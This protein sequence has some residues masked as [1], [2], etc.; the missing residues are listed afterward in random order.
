M[1]KRKKRSRGRKLKGSNKEPRKPKKT[2][3]KKIETIQKLAAKTFDG[4]LPE[5][6]EFVKYSSFDEF[7]DVPLLRGP[8][9][10]N[11]KI[12]DCIYLDPSYPEVLPKGTI[13]G[14]I[15]K[16]NYCCSGPYFYYRDKSLDCIQC[17]ENFTFSA[18]EQKYWYESLQFNLGS[19]AIRCKDCRKQRR[20]VNSLFQQISVALNKIKE[21]PK[22]PA[23]Y[24][25]DVEATIRLH[26]NTGEGNLDRALAHARKARKLDKEFH[27][28]IYWEAMVQI[29]KGKNKEAKILLEKFLTIIGDE[30]RYKRLNKAAKKILSEL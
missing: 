28:A 11:G 25:I 4:K 8:R 1:S 6:V 26:K 19:I 30:P 9:E 18:E 17:N 10:F 29:Q 7:I 5:G 3:K 23:H 16:Q 2:E 22:N 14:D 24:I 12:Y 15:T 20:S 13:R 27:E 21:N